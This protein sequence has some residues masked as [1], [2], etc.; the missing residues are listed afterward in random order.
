MEPRIEILDEKTLVG[1]HLD[2]RLAQ[3]RTAELWRAFMPRRGEVKNRANPHFISMQVYDK[4]QGAP[5]A[6]ATKFEKWAAVEVTRL[7]DVPEGME[8]Y[9]MS[10]GK[11]AVFIHKGPASSA[12]KTFQHIFGVWLPESQYELDDRE[13]FEVLPPEYRPDDPN[14]VEEVWVPIK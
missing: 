2:M 12:F 9:I 6:P 3:N 10:G 14:A 7:N 11:Y 5:F 8:S 1:M 4:A 13:H